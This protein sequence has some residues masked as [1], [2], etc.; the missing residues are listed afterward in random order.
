MALLWAIRRTCLLP[1]FLTTTAAGSWRRFSAG[2]RTWSLKG[3]RSRSRRTIR[4]S[5]IVRS[6]TL[7]SPSRVGCVRSRCVLRPRRAARC[8]ITFW[9]ISTRMRRTLLR[10]RSRF[11]LGGAN[12]NAGGGP[13]GAGLL[14]EWAV[15]KNYDIYRTNAGKLLMPGAKI[16]W[17][18]HTHSVGEEITDHPQLAVYLYP[19]GETPK[20][21]TYLNAV[22]SDRNERL[23]PGHSAELDR[24]E[25]GFP[26][27]E[28]SGTA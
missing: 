13:A 9:R 2:S 8:S 17:E 10:R 12:A 27:A 1:R 22:R 11:D 25:P 6:P 19:K 26:C 5:G 24:R 18:Y 7:A 23:A 28:G 14:M 16:R 3:R 21:R 20:Y 15:G 4:I